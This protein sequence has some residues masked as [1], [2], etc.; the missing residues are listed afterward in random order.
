MLLRAGY[1][2]ALV[3]GLVVRERDELPGEQASLVPIQV[4]GPALYGLHSDGTEVEQVEELLEL[5]R[6]AVEAIEMPNDDGSRLAILELMEQLLVRGSGAVIIGGDGFVDERDRARVAELGGEGG[7][8]GS[9]L[10]D[11]GMFA[12][13]IRGD[14]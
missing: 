2:G 6:L 13:A 4:E 5:S 8:V 14:P 12:D 3:S 9:L 10:L 1:S 7:A 11:G